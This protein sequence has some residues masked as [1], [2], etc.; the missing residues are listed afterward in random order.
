MRRLRAQLRLEVLALDS[1]ARR[2]IGQALFDSPLPLF[3][4]RTTL[5]RFFRSVRYC[6]FVGFLVDVQFI[7]CA[8]LCL[9]DGW[10]EASVSALE[11]DGCG[12]VCSVE[13]GG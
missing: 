13:F 9:F 8:I 11:I 12:R 6:A 3:I 5:P 7:C 10:R 4:L 2:L 1:S